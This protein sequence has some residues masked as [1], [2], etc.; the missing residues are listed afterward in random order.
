MPV[1]FAV[2]IAGVPV[3]E[4]TMSLLLAEVL[5]LVAG[6]AA[7]RLLE[8]A[9]EWRESGRA[10]VGPLTDVLK[11]VVSFGVGAV[12][13]TR[14]ERKRGEQERQALLELRQAIDEDVL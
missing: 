8:I 9:R 1:G 7:G 5:K 11:I 6:V 14:R 2:S 4:E 13:A 3:G 12:V 10:P